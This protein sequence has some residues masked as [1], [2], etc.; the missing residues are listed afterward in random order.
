MQTEALAPVLPP[1]AGLPT[2]VVS[3]PATDMCNAAAGIVPIA[4]VWQSAS[5]QLYVCVKSFCTSHP[6][7]PAPPMPPPPVPALP[8]L[9]LP[10]PQPTPTRA[11]ASTAPPMSVRT[12]CETVDG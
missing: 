12:F 5:V 8:V 9:S 2:I 10:G 7:V 4:D 11:S 3:Q 6:P 1:G